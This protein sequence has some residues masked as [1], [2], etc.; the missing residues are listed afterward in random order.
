M[1]YS[2]QFGVQSIA[3][4]LGCVLTIGRTLIPLREV[5]SVRKDRRLGVR[6]PNHGF[7]QACKQACPA[8]RWKAIT[9]LVVMAGA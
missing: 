7:A 1:V 5:L 8:P 3:P 9:F 2:Y 4:A 6:P